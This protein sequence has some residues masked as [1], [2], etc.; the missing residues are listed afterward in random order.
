MTDRPGSAA[1]LPHDDS[2]KL[3]WKS[4]KELG[5]SQNISFWTPKQPFEDERKHVTGF[6]EKNYSHDEEMQEPG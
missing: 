4:K 5:K 6:D 2:T 3:E 1:S